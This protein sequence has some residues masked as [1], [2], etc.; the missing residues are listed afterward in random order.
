MFRALLKVVLVLVILALAAIAVGSIFFPQKLA[1]LAADAERGAAGLA[2]KETDIPGFHVVYLEGGQGEPLLLIHGFGA[3]KDNWT[4]VARFLTPHYRVIAPDLPGFGESSKPV[5][6]RYRIEDQVGYVH[7]IAQKLGL[8]NLHL[9]GNSMGGN[10]A[11]A[12]AAR[13]PE[14]V[15]S[16]WLLAPAGVSTSEPSE[17]GGILKAGGENP[18]VARTP[19]EF[20]RVIRFVM[21]DPPY[22]PGAIK[23]VMAARA[24]TNYDLHQK[25]F[26]GL[27]ESPLPLEPLL[28]GL[29]TPTRIL[30]G[31]K[32]R[33]L[34]VS[35]ANI[36]A[37]LMPNASTTIMS[38]I[39]HLPMLERPKQSAEDYVG[40]R[41]SLE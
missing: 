22:I 25:I 33:A 39:G 30:W 37:G 1:L 26:K 17:L 20:D 18:L 40:F 21:E 23:K 2:V 7:A 32:D 35:G 31:D 27:I 11:A 24:A 15:K 34:H 13:Y 41:S 10:I 6:A 29:P 14:E 28:Q 12:Y 16:L 9:G 3:D 8:K 4:R 5:D 38:G 19:K 36:L